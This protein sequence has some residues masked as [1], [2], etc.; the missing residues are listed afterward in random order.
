MGPLRNFELKQHKFTTTYVK[1]QQAFVSE[2][3][4]DFGNFAIIGYAAPG[5]NGV[6]TNF[7]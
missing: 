4:M 3:G 6:T 1:L 2:T 7:T 5:K